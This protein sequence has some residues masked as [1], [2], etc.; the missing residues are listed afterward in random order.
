MPEG[1]EGILKSIGDV[2]E[3]QPTLVVVA[4]PATFH[5]THVKLLIENNVP[6]IIE[7]PITAS[8]D[9]AKEIYDLTK[10]NKTSF[11]T[12]GYCL[13]FLPAA[14]I[15]KSFI[16]SGELGE[17]YNI[18]AEV[19][20]YLPSWRSDKNY[21]DSVS[22]RKE[23]GGGVLLEISHEFDYLNWF[24][25]ELKPV[26]AKLRNSQELNLKVEEIADV[27]LETQTGAL[28]YVHLDFLQKA[29]R[30]VMSV[31]ARNGRLTWDVLANNVM[32]DQLEK[33]TLLYED[34]NYDKNNMYLNQLSESFACIQSGASPLVSVHSSVVVL[35]QIEKIKL[36]A[37]VSS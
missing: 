4:S 24:F 30:R 10:S 20:Q 26:Y 19:G 17:I 7:K 14:Q 15:V 35:E 1:V 27:V 16:D 28:C 36:L 2:L 6:V 32:Y 21:T 23:L 37:G 11:V 8:Y 18:N 5:K 22:A 31:T 13:R 34:K 29:T 3:L 33:T 9:D 25:G 12:V